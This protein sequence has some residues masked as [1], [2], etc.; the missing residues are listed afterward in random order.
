MLMSAADTVVIRE[1]MQPSDVSTADDKHVHDAGGEDDKEDG[2]N[3]L[4][5]L[6]RNDTSVH[7]K[8]HALSHHLKIL[9]R[10]SK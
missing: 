7:T 6:L 3:I 4:N 9:G 5:D 2:A 10:L 1:H 8:V